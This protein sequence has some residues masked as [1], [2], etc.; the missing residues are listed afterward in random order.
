MKFPRV[1]VLSLLFAVLGH[2]V[3]LW[4][5][6]VM[7]ISI[8]LPHASHPCVAIPGPPKKKSQEL[9]CL[10][11]PDQKRVTE[12]KTSLLELYPETLPAIP[13]PGHTELPI[14]DAAETVRPFHAPSYPPLPHPGHLATPSASCI[15]PPRFSPHISKLQPLFPC[16]PSSGFTVVPSCSTLNITLE[17]AQRCYRPG[18]VFKITCTPKEGV[19]FRRWKQAYYFV[20]DRSSSTSRSH[21][22]MNK[23]LVS[24]ALDSLLPGDSFNILLFDHQLKTFSAEPVAWS[25]EAVVRAQSFLDT[26]GHGGHLAPSNVGYA[27]EQALPPV[28]TNERA[29]VVLL[30][31]DGDPY[32]TLERQ[33]KLLGN[34]ASLH[35]DRHSLH[36]VTIGPGHPIGLFKLF[37]RLHRGSLLHVP[38]PRHLKNAFDSFLLSLQHPIGQHMTATMIAEDPQAHIQLQPTNLLLPPLYRSPFVLYGSTHRLTDAVLFLQGTA[39]EGW[40]DIKIPLHLKEA[41]YG[42]PKIEAEWCEHLVSELYE[43]FL[44][45]GHRGHLETA[46]RMLAPFNLSIPFNES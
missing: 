3:A 38:D 44:V 35:H 26:Q 46:Q 12:W 9:C 17:V 36:I 39:E 18:F 1:F 8:S 45:D 21:F 7:P 42:S 11:I 13:A 24:R 30:F 33:R 41:A 40:F 31:S 22:V 32:M 16:V 34:W 6:Q 23:Q 10:P 4:W 19:V 25:H 5:I 2:G 37:S 29:H 14:W 28:L 15:E 20:L 43:Q 27:M